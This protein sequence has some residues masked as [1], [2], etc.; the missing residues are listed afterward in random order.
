MYNHLTQYQT[1]EITL[2]GTYYF[3]TTSTGNS[4]GINNRHDGACASR[5]MKVKMIVCCTSSTK[6]SPQGN[7]TLTTR[8][9]SRT[10]ARP[11]E[12]T[13]SPTTTTTQ[14]TTRPTTTTTT[15]RTTKITTP[16]ITTTAKLPGG[17]PHDPTDIII[18]APGTLD[19]VGV[20]NSAV[21]INRPST[22]VLIL[23]AFLL[24]FGLFSR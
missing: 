12:T 1:P 5:N 22:F 21:T 20:I 4:Q 11:S 3:I 9:P 6:S 10:T 19:N 13:R 7:T 2:Q 18:D 17:K 15:K 8:E 16:V 24:T 14:T 23:T